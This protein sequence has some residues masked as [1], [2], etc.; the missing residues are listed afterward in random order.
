MALDGVAGEVPTL[1]VALLLQA[2]G[3][4]ADVRDLSCDR[5][6]T[7]INKAFRDRVPRIGRINGGDHV[8]VEA[9][10]IL[11]VIARGRC[12]PWCRARGAPRRDDLPVQERD[13]PEEKP[14][15]DG[16]PGIAGGNTVRV[17]KFDVARLTAPA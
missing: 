3:P 8:V 10:Q 9:D 16:D 17:Y 4:A 11:S 12:S 2:G 1:A 15:P 13:A 5:W 14:A 6:Q 7:L